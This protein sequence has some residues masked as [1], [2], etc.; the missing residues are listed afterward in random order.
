[1][2]IRQII[3]HWKNRILLSNQTFNLGDIVMLKG[4]EMDCY[5]S[6]NTEYVI[7]N[8]G[9]GW[10]SVQ[11]EIGR[12]YHGGMNSDKFKLIR[13]KEKTTLTNIEINFDKRKI[14]IIKNN[15]THTITSVCNKLDID[16]V[17]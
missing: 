15:R 12:D 1:M 17:N 2:K 5:V 6:P 14:T 3:K 8:I 13:K 7:S 10:I 11:N 4:D 16:L 9:I